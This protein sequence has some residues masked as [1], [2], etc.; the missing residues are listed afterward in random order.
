MATAS[1]RSMTIAVAIMIVLILLKC[2][3]MLKMI[4]IGMATRVKTHDAA[5]LKC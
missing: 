5:T 4:T 2:V 1:I 3:D